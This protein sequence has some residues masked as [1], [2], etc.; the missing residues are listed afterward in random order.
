[1]I[2]KPES[3]M[4]MPKSIFVDLN[5]VLDVV[6][7][8]SGWEVAE[9]VI[10]QPLD[11]P[12]RMYMSAHCVT[13]FAYVLESA[14]VPHL[15]RQR[16]IDWL[17]HTFTIIPVGSELLL[18]AVTSKLTDYEDAVVEQ[19]AFACNASVIITRNLKDFKL[20]LVPASLPEDYLEG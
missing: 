17:L 5:I 3:G 2:L 4:L 18:A 15:Q 19:A 7:Q 12:L 16:Q 14:K 6:L 1:M 8:R 20:S 9:Q 10:T 13:T 11:S